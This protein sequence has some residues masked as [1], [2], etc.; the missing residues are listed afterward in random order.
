MIDTT[1]VF[2]MIQLQGNVTP[3]IEAEVIALQENYQSTLES[4][5]TGFNIPIKGKFALRTLHEIIGKITDFKVQRDLYSSLS[6][7]F[8]EVYKAS[9]SL[10]VNPYDIR[11]GYN[12]RI[13]IP[14]Y[15]NSSGNYRNKS[16]LGYS[17]KFGISEY[18]SEYRN[19]EILDLSPD[20]LSLLCKVLNP[21]N[22]KFRLIML[23]EDD[24]GEINERIFE[25]TEIG[26]EECYDAFI[27]AIEAVK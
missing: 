2:V 4:I 19:Q 15:L 8:E 13:E 3:E 7:L 16:L 1:E 24:K 26:V 25:G 27:K 10:G 22:K 23:T 18:T 20:K 12:S 11:W 6:I 5:F 9:I 17:V 14:H 21:E